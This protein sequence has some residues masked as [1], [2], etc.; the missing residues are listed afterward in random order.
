MRT[1]LLALMLLT[2]IG[3]SLGSDKSKEDALKSAGLLLGLIQACHAADPTLPTAETGVD[4]AMELLVAGGYDDASATTMAP[5]MAKRMLSMADQKFDR[6]QC[7]AFL[8]QVR[9]GEA[10][11]LEQLRSEQ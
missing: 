7:V 4:E 3:S 6:D 8:A 1:M 11:A 10:A 5:E 2:T 9:A